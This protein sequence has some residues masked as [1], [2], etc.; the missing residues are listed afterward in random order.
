DG[1]S[2]FG[3]MRERYPD[4]ALVATS[5]RPDPEAAAGEIRHRLFCYLPGRLAAE[6]ILRTAFEATQHIHLTRLRRGSLLREG[7]EQEPKLGDVGRFEHS[8]QLA[9]DKLW[10]A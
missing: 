7:L 9:L 5:R 2:L 6:Q 8:F 3:A 10:M 4:S 1:G